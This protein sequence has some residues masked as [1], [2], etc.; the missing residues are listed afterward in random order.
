MPS[1][2]PAELRDHD[3]LAELYADVQRLG[4]PPPRMRRGPDMPPPRTMPAP[5]AVVAARAPSAP[6]PRPT[7]TLGAPS[8]ELFAH[9]EAT[10]AKLE[11]ELADLHQAHRLAQNALTQSRSDLAEAHGRLEGAE[12]ARADLILELTVARRDL[13]R[14]EDRDRERVRRIQAMETSSTPGLASTDLRSLLFARGLRGEDE[15]CAA[16][17]ALAAARRVGPLLAQLNTPLPESFAEFLLERLVLLAPGESPEAGAAGVEVS[18]ERSDLAGTGAIDR[19]IEEFSAACLLM[20]K[21][22]VLIVGGTPSYR[23]QLQN[24]VDKRIQLTL[25]D[26]NRKNFRTPARP[27]F[28]IVWGATELDHA[29][30]DHF[31]DAFAVHHRGITGMLERVTARLL[32]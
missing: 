32:A 5:T 2:K 6:L 25:V 14:A 23:N 29:S 27:D 21:R 20:G 22:R 1:D 10:R 8:P 26:G 13:T 24:G 28:T 31:P 7:S 9:V 17:G 30:S 11:A 4:E 12:R 19:A 18:A 15:M 3:L 16:I